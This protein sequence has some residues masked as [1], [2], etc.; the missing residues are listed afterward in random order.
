MLVTS[1]RKNKKCKNDNQVASS[2]YFNEKATD[3]LIRHIQGNIVLKIGIQ[4]IP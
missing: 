3:I 1:M 2:N 4:G